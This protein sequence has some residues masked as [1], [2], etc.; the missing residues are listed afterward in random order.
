MA[1][2]SSEVV[3]ADRRVIVS[4]SLTDWAVASARG[5][6]G[7]SPGRGP[8][9]HVVSWCLKSG[10]FRGPVRRR[11]FYVGIREVEE[12]VPLAEY[13]RFRRR[14]RCPT[15]SAATDAKGGSSEVGF[16]V[17][18]VAIGISQHIED[19]LAGSQIRSGSGRARRGTGASQKRACSAKCR[20][21]L[22]GI[23]DHGGLRI[24]GKLLP[25]RR[26]M[27][28][29]TNSVSVQ[30]KPKNVATKSILRAFV[31]SC[32]RHD[33][34][35]KPRTNHAREPWGTSLAKRTSVVAMVLVVLV[36]GAIHG[37]SHLPPLACA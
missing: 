13:R 24:R 32:I 9:P 2:G 34:C 29:G 6:L 30:A 11:C 28:M 14:R 20:P 26:A 31:R 12:G 1:W 15:S 25:S 27:P 16:Q 7:G 5:R 3:G 18:P 23:Q 35:A 21:R 19:I 37:F 8:T 17:P 10:R 4:T 36:L 33:A 22:W